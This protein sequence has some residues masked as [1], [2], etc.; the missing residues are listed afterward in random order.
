MSQ[1][2]DLNIL[3]FTVIACISLV[4]ILIY[5]VIT[6]HRVMYVVIDLICAIPSTAMYKMNM[7]NYI[8]KQNIL[9]KMDKL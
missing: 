5:N 2:Y 9:A 4:V 8:R 7:T 6:L 3:M 1:A